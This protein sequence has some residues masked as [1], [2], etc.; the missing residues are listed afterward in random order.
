MDLFKVITKHNCIKNLSFLSFNWC[1]NVVIY[2]FT[3]SFDL[4]HE[5]ILTL[6][7]I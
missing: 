6:N 7:N 2:L 3:T 5:N 4:N 1:K